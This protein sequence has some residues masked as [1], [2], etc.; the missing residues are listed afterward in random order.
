MGIDTTKGLE[1]LVVLQHQFLTGEPG[2]HGGIH[3]MGMQDHL[4]L[5]K[6][7][8]D[9]HM[10]AGL[11]RGATS[12]QGLS[13]AVDEHDVILAQATLVPA[14]YGNGD[15]PIGQARRKVAA[16]SRHHTTLVEAVT[17]RNELG[18]ALL[19]FAGLLCRCGHAL[20]PG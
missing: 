10:Q 12:V 19:K 14:G 1:Q 9:L 3:G 4:G 7:A 13:L 11:R 5:G 15:L 8:I 20:D 17:R 6:V 2:Q 18:C 16:G